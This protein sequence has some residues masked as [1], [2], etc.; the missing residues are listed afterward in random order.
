MTRIIYFR[1]SNFKKIKVDIEDQTVTLEKDGSSYC[2]QFD[3]VELLPAT[4]R[5]LKYH[6]TGELQLNVQGKQLLLTDSTS[7]EVLYRG[8]QFSF[9]NKMVERIQLY[10]NKW[11][12]SVCQQKIL[13]QSR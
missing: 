12:C 8:K 1:Q 3:D 2:Y 4:C 11:F 13:N 6:S 9:Q 5:G 10:Q 7:D